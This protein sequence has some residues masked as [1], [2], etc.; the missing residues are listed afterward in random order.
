MMA[1]ASRTISRKAGPPTAASGALDEGST[2]AG[3]PARRASDS[4]ASAAPRLPSR[5]SA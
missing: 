4:A 5:S 1:P 2:E 3:M